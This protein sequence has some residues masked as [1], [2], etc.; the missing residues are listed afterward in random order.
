MDQKKATNTIARFSQS[1][2][3]ATRASQRSLSFTIGETLVFNPVVWVGVWFWVNGTCLFC[4]PPWSL[5]GHIFR[6]FVSCTGPEEIV[7]EISRRNGGII[8]EKKKRKKPAK[9]KKS[10]NLMK[11][12]QKNFERD[13][14]NFFFFASEILG[15]AKAKNHEQS[16]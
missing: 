10:G 7:P 13:P 1:R 2:D 15:Y 4:E 14:R 16:S 8:M 3:S 6:F 5:P 12:A 9:K 11:R